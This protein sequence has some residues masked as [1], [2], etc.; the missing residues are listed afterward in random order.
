MGCS[1]LTSVTIPDS[2]TSIDDYAFYDC[3]GLTRVT[4]PE[5]VT[6]IGYSFYGCSSLFTID[7][8]GTIEQWEKIDKEDYGDD[9]DNIREI[10]CIDGIIKII[11][12]KKCSKKVK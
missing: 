7:Y 6:H 10:H 4:I 11:K 2:V 5:S 9:Y 1:G 12:S 3:T 8:N